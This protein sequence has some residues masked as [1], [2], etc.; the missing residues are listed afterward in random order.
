MEDTDSDYSSGEALR[1]I[2]GVDLHT[3][4]MYGNIWPTEQNSAGP[5]G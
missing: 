4:E 1:W 3:P 5:E 2:I